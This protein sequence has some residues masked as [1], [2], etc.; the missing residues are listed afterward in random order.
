[1]EHQDWTTVVL[2]KN[3]NTTAKKTT[4]K[5]PVSKT[6]SNNTFSGTG[7]KINDEDEPKKLP[8]VGIVVGKQIAQARC[9]KKLSQKELAAKINML[10]NVVQQYEN[11]KA[12][13]NNSLLAKFERVLGV[14]LKR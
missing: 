11:G 4:T 7:K 1:M 6:N 9:A 8:T 3:K 14:K 12:L 2:K 13:R 10:P 5:V